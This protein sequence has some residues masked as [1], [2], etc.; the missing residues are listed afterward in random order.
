[1]SGASWLHR[2]AL[3]NAPAQQLTVSTAAAP[4]A[5]VV[6]ACIGLEA[7]TSSLRN[8]CLE[9]LTYLMLHAATRHQLLML[10]EQLCAIRSCHRMACIKVSTLTA[11][12][13]IQHRKHTSSYSTATAVAVIPPVCSAAHAA[14]KA[15][16]WPRVSAPAL[17]RVAIQVLC[18]SV[19]VPSWH[20]RMIL[21]ALNELQVIQRLRSC[22]L[23]CVSLA[24]HMSKL[25]Y[26]VHL[27]FC[28]SAGCRSCCAT[29][30]CLACHMS[31]L[32]CHFARI[33]LFCRP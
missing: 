10:I 19:T 9:H 18:C 7:T 15:C 32:P 2:W 11:S 28:C 31:E 5:A 27:S 23:T 33:L 13:C 16:A 3:R 17:S 12:A 14:A 8:H 24:C 22:C 30:V 4:A 25:T 21:Q 1:M 29:R 20:F 26:V 6:F